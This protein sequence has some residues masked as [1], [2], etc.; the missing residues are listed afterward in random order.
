MNETA[1]IKKQ[2]QTY[3]KHRSYIEAA[4][5]YGSFAKGHA[6]IKGDKDT[7][8]DVDVGLLLKHDTP[9]LFTKRLKITRDLQKMLKR[10][11]DLVFLN[12]TSPVLCKQVLEFGILAYCRNKRSLSNFFC[13]T[14]TGYSD[15]RLSRKEIEEKIL[16]EAA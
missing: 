10:E 8:S 14:I 9:L 12:D 6:R 13:R 16:N 4:Y 2:L 11:I 7:Q 5:L 15:L 1:I 3:F